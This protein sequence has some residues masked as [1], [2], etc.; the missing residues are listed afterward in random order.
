MKGAFGALQWTPE[1]FWRSTLTEYMLAI[2]GFNEL[3]DGGKRDN[4]PSD[5]DLATLLAK[6]G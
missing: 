5:D 3:N 6:Y 4:G 2:D 1:T